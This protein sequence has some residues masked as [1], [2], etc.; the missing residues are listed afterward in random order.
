LNLI[1]RKVD[2]LPLVEYRA[3]Q[4]SLI[5]SLIDIS[6]DYLIANGV[7]IKK[8]ETVVSIKD[9]M[10][11][12]IY[13]YSGNYY[14]NIQYSV[15]V[16]NQH[17]DPFLFLHIPKLQDNKFILNSSE[18]IPMIYLADSPIVF[19]GRSIM[20]YS[21]FGSITFD[22]KARRVIYEGSNI[23]ISRFLRIFYKDSDIPNVM[24]DYEHKVINETRE[25]SLTL[26]SA[27]FNTAPNWKSLRIRINRLFFD[28]WTVG[29]YD[30][31]YGFKTNDLR[32]VLDY[33]KNNIHNTKADDFI[34]LKYKRVIFAEQLLLPI[35]RAVRSLIIRHLKGNVTGNIIKLKISN[36]SEISNYFFKSMS[37][38]T[39]YESTNV[40]SSLTLFKA[41]FKR[42]GS[43]SNL[44]SCVSSIHSTYKGVIDPVVVSNSNPG[45]I[46]ALVPTTNI[47]MKYGCIELANGGDIL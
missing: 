40:Y 32:E 18:Y 36:P 10:N 5:P 21:L 44:P 34:N 42:P 24:P 1:K 22:R 14:A 33:V 16:N 9:S 26:L 25:R 30:R 13:R 3:Y 37:G 31:I 43:T 7:K 11:N 2:N 12:S 6:I 23:P 41:S 46:V 29:L 27:I 28:R 8:D 45:E 20:L 19:K 47:D 38:S 4:M 17:K 35:F 15:T 39:L